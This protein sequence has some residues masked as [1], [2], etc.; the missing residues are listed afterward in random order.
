MSDVLI[1]ADYEL[2]AR[3]LNCPLPILKAKKSIRDLKPGLVLH[4]IA[5]DSG[6]ANDF[7]LFCKQTGNELIEMTSEDNEYHFYI[8]KS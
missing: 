6:S 3:G 5:T 7:P 8:R 2:D 1:K 4:V